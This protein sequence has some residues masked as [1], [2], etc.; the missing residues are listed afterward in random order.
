VTGGTPQ[1]TGSGVELTHR[2]VMTVM[3]GLLLALFLAAL[4]GTVVSTALPT[5][6]GDLG[7]LDQLPWVLTAYLLTSTASTPLWG[8]ISDLRGRRRTF[9]VSIVWFL[10]A[11]VLC[12]AAPNM[13]WLVLGRGLQGIGGGG[14]M[15]LTFVIIGDLV[16]PRDR[17]RYMGWFTGTFTVASLLGPLIGGF[18]VD[19]ASWRWIFYV[20]IPFGIVALVVVGRV[21]RTSVP[22]VRRRLDIE[23]AGLLVTAVVALILVM[24]FGGDRYPWTA[25]EILGL[26]VVF[27]GATAAFLWQERRAPEPL[28]PLRLFHNRTVA[29][30]MFASVC[31][32]A[33]M[34]A[35]G[36]FL[37]LFLQVVAGSSATASGLALAPMMV[38]LTLASVVAGNLM[39]RLGRY[40]VFLV[41]GPGLTVVGLAALTRLDADATWVTLA[42]WMVLLGTGMGLFMPTTTTVTQNALP[43]AD[44]GVGTATL[45]FARNL[46]QTVGVGAFG[47]ALAGRIDSVLTERLPP[48]SDIDV[49]EL[50]STPQEIRL[51]PAELQDAVVDAVGQATTLVFALAVPVAVAILVA[52]IFIPEVPLRRWSAH[53]GAGAGAGDGDDADGAVASGHADR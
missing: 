25:P 20:K 6:A 39:A 15:A 28:I 13:F 52:S 22:P 11:S 24:V 19:N 17:G 30:A 27:V 43:L 47:A 1:S 3:G 34:M 9:Q 14:M 48:G 33:A 41:V 44:L 46:G 36:S 50:L 51:L 38:M 29:L 21:L 53:A 16:S 12:G 26:T 18:F 8:K 32:G 31:A 40:K 5:M 10:A 2:E 49:S 37:P 7:G 4:D 42:P 23:G 35:A 45:T